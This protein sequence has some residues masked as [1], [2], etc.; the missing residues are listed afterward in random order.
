MV[1]RINQEQ[2]HSLQKKIGAEPNGIDRLFVQIN[3]KVGA[4]ME[5]FMDTG[6]FDLDI[7]EMPLNDDRKGIATYS[8]GY[9]P[10]LVPTVVRLLKQYVKEHGDSFDRLR[11]YEKSSNKSF[12]DYFEEKTGIPYDDLVD[13]EPY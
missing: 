2:F 3:K 10:C 5:Y 4:V 6:T 11:K 7:L 12:A 9:P 13:F 1:E 8:H